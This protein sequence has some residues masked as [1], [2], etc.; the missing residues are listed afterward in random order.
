[1]KFFCAGVIGS[2]LLLACGDDDDPI[3]AAVDG[4]MEMGLDA[5]VEAATDLGGDAASDLGTDG[6]VCV[7]ACEVGDTRCADGAVER[8]ELIDEC[9]AFQ[10]AE[11]C[12][13]G[14]SFCDSTAD[15]VVCAPG[16][17]GDFDCDGV[18]PADDCDDEDPMLGAR[19]ADMDCD[20]VLTDDDCDDNDPE[21]LTV[22]DDADCDGVPPRVDCDPLDADVGA[23]PTDADCDSQPDIVVFEKADGAD[24][25]LAENQ[26][27][28]TDAVCIT[29]GDDDGIYNAVDED[30]H[31]GDASPSGASMASGFAGQELT[32]SSWSDAILGENWAVRQ[33]L[34]LRLAGDG[35]EFNT[36]SFSWTAAEGA[37]G[38]GF[39]WARA[40]VRRF[41]KEADADPALPANQDCFT[42]GVCITRASS[43]SFYNAVE[44]D[45]FD[46]SGPSGTEWAA[47]AT[48]DASAADYTTFSTAVPSP[49]DAVGDVISMH[50]LDTNL[51]FDIVI[52]RFDGGASGG[53]FAWSRSRAIVFGCT[54]PSAENYDPRASVDEGFCGEWVLFE[55]PSGADPELPENQDCIADDVCIAR[56]ARDGLYNA[57]ASSIYTP[58]GPSGTLWTAAERP[59]VFDPADY[60]GWSSTIGRSPAEAYV[61]RPHGLWLFTHR[62]VFDIVVRRYP[63]ASSDGGITYYRREVASVGV[64]GDDTLDLGEACD[65]GNADDG[66]GCQSNCLLEGCG[67]GIVED[68]E[69][70]DTGALLGGR[71]GL[72]CRPGCELGGCGDGIVDTDEACDD[73]N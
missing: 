66:D 5:P 73:G 55:S 12:E 41:V 62:R 14:V 52:T 63:L 36:R 15:P 8:C 49:R 9:E 61:N 48:A 29:R 25:S 30:A 17:E 24:A 72:V 23:D 38:G 64:C 31:D 16:C 28:I 70:C 57:A 53:G 37:D 3:D 54:D 71:A 56:N 69:A 42:P 4:A 46:G 2:L 34:V 19:A 18:M 6:S 21:S 47:M 22:A 59:A 50:I 11:S 10:R 60:L 40:G 44:E 13:E 20:G 67:N 39:G 26:D 33:P 68:G 65:D 58:P 35:Q 43:R 45:S 27:C 7:P 1:M 32:F 51:Y